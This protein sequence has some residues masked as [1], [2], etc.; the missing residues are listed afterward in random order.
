MKLGPVRDLETCQQFTRRSNGTLKQGE[1]FHLK[2][3][4]TINEALTKVTDA[5]TKREK[6]DSEQAELE[7][8]RKEEEERK[9]DGQESEVPADR[10]HDV[11]DSLWPGGVRLI[12]PSEGW[13]APTQPTETGG[14]GGI[15]TLGRRERT[16]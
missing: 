15:R 12:L 3:E 1:E 6:Q 9:Q 7:R 11:W 14:G 2:A 4:T 16:P 13:V 10:R 8:L 5:T